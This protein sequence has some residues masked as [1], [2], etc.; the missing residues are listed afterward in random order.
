MGSKSVALCRSVQDFKDIMTVNI[1]GPFLVT[2]AL[3]PLIQKGGKKQ[4][5]FAQISIL[6]NVRSR[7]NIALRNHSVY[8]Y[9]SEGA[10]CKSANW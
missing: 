2:Q 9:H 8:S 6:I 10:Y 5:E 4:V 7:D 1:L 3:L